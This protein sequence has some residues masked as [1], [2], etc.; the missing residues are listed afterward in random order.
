VDRLTSEQDA[1]RREL[2]AS[3]EEWLRGL[4]AA[5]TPHDLDLVLRGLTEASAKATAAMLAEARALLERRS[6]RP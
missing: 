5:E 6:R 3:C 4:R 2:I 1:L